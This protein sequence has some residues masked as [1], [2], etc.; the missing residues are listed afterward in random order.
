MSTKDEF[1]E[2]ARTLAT[3][4]VA[5]D[6]SHEQKAGLIAANMALVARAARIAELEWCLEEV[7]E[8]LPSSRR[9]DMIVDRLTKL[10]KGTP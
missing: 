5:H 7:A 4:L 2:R 6:G 9:Q 10:K 8:V 1:D 3:L